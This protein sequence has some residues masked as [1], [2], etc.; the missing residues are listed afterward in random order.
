ML[1]CCLPTCRGCGFRKAKKHS[2]FSC[3]T[4]W[5][6]P[7]LHRLWPFGRRSPQS[8][9]QEVVEELADGF[10]Y[11]ISLD[12]DQLHRT[13]INNQGCSESE[14]ESTLSVTEA[15]RMRALQSV[16]PAFLAESSAVSSPPSAATQAPA[17]PTRCWTSCF[18]GPIY[19]PSQAMPSSPLGHMEAAWPIV[20]R[21]LE[22]RTTSQ[23]LSISC[24]EPGWAKGRIAGSPC[25]TLQLATLHTSFGGSHVEGHA[26]LLP[27]HLEH[28]KAIEAEWKGEGTGARASA[29][30]WAGASC[31]SSLTT[32]GR[33]GASSP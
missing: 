12:R 16:L 1:C 31:T 23:M 26:Y 28:L 15:C 24:W 13:I 25:W 5:L 32:C 22:D 19:P 3:Y 11:S 20:C 27:G 4:H 21:M 7:H 29:S 33:A 18:P 14:D 6:G 9:T 17:Q 10:G 30:P 2:L 8:C